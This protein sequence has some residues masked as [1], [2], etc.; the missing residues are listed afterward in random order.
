MEDRVVIVIVV[1]RFGTM[2]GKVDIT[3]TQVCGTQWDFNTSALACDMRSFLNI[4][5]EWH[6]RCS[7][8]GAVIDA[9]ETHSFE[10][11]SLLTRLVK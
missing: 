2:I 9:T 11:N 10:C 5:S 3:Q 7:S 1:V 8:G 6:R 4:V